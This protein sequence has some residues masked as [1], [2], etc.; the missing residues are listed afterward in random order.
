MSIF[1]EFFSNFLKHN[2][3]MLVT[4]IHTPTK[5][6]F[7]GLY[8]NQPVCPP[9]CLCI[10]PSVCPFVHLCTKYSFCQSAGGDITSHLVT[11]LVSPLATMSVPFL[12]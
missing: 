7:S 3:K 8:C 5:L 1:N 4:N 12:N 11:A 2:E 9:V 6:M 10:G